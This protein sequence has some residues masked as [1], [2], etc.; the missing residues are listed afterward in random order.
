MQGSAS[1]QAALSREVQHL[2]W[3]YSLQGTA[4]APPGSISHCGTRDEASFLPRILLF[5]QTTGNRSWILVY[6][7][8]WDG[9]HPDLHLLY[10][11]SS[12]SRACL[13][14][15]QHTTAI[16][17]Q[18]SHCWRLNLKILHR[19]PW[20]C[21]LLQLLGISSG[22]GSR[23]ALRTQDAAAGT[24]LATKLAVLSTIFLTSGGG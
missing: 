7:S 18:Q 23:K 2:P 16:S 13:T 5:L 9:F 17:L 22:E 6:G 14:P 20:H 4:T 15:P 11:P 10:P 19:E 21:H 3:A 1:K 24:Y 12:S 8:L